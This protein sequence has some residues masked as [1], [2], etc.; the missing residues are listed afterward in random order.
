[1]PV[2]PLLENAA[3]NISVPA[4]ECVLLYISLRIS[5]KVE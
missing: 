4:I 5:S 1:M 3:S 2:L